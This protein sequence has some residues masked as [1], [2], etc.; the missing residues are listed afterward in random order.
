MRLFKSKLRRHTE[1]KVDA[2]Q[3]DLAKLEAKKNLL[4]SQEYAMLWSKQKDLIDQIR[5]LKSIL[6]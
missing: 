3:I 6:Q 4:N 1:A 2:L 5:L